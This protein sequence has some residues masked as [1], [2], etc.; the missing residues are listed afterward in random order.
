MLASPVAD[1]LVWVWQL[2]EMGRTPL[3]IEESLGS[4][5][6]THESGFAP[7]NILA[8]GVTDE[9]GMVT[10]NIG[11]AEGPLLF[12]AETGYAL[13]PGTA[14]EALLEDFVA[15]GVLVLDFFEDSRAER[16]FTISPITTAAHAMAS[17]QAH[18]GAYSQLIEHYNR[19]WSE[20]IGEDITRAQAVDIAS[21]SEIDAASSH[22]CVSMGESGDARSSLCVPG[23]RNGLALAALH[24]MAT[25]IAAEQ[26]NASI[27][28]EKGGAGALLGSLDIA[29][30]LVEDASPTRPDDPGSATVAVLDG[31]G[32][33]GEIWLGA[34]PVE[35]NTWRSVWGAAL[36]FEVVPAQWNLTGIEVSDLEAM[37]RGIALNPEGDL[38]GDAPVSPLAVEPPV[39]SFGPVEL[40]DE[41]HDE[42]AFDP[43]SASP[44]HTATAWIQLGGYDSPSRG[45]CPTLHKHITRLDDA[46]DNAIRWRFS[47]LP[48]IP[49]PRIDERAELRVLLRQP[50]ALLTADSVT[51][52]LEHQLV[53]LTDW[54]PADLLGPAISED[55]T[56]E[57]FAFETVL[58]LRDI[59]ELG[60]V[61]R[62]IFE[63]EIRAKDGLGQ[64]AVARAC[65]KH[66]LLPPPLEISALR[67]VPPEDGQSLHAHG[68]E[69]NNLGE[70]LNGERGLSLIELEI[71]NGTAY[72]GYIRPSFDQSPATITVSWQRANALLEVDNSNTHETCLLAATCS[73]DFPPNR[74][75]TFVEDD[76]RTALLV[77]HIELYDESMQRPIEPCTESH[78]CASG[79]YRLEPRFDIRQPSVYRI[80]LV[81]GDLSNLSPEFLSRH[82][83]DV[84]G[85]YMEF[86]LDAL[87]TLHL[88][89]RNYE[90][91][92]VCHV[93]VDNS[94]STSSLYR[95]HRLLSFASVSIPSMTA[96]IASS[97]IG[98]LLSPRKRAIRYTDY[99]WTTL[100]PVLPTLNP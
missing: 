95:H 3:D 10:L 50:S 78:D 18:L 57:G 37:A 20:H 24:G 31:T 40:A 42:I 66:V 41:I 1:S 89:G 8:E 32:P 17:S 39:L 28:R 71:R 49:G 38:F 69:R 60:A 97:A 45:Q 72:P 36:A 19:R 22:P 51:E 70:L 54:L 15:R 75:A 100:E 92:R 5:D 56:R 2:D 26:R 73:R 46:T 55:E 23:M 99:F 25:R 47:V 13:E 61:G 7:A 96:V 85:P 63:I 34:Y 90:Q 81:A 53:P 16:P 91:I 33:D 83:D 35:A 65:W 52:S 76:V 29:R 9:R 84:G 6:T 80:A 21:P 77:S 44:T 12:E 14:E 88:S 62:G 58:L 30:A 67:E 43:E 79:V 87:Q 68:L 4:G 64:E 98:L 93:A 74:Q 59:P 27:S 11:Q 94:C 82:D 86:T 48:G